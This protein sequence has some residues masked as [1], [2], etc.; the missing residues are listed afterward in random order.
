[1]NLI[2]LILALAVAC[3]SAAPPAR[4]FGGNLPLGKASGRA[5]NGREKRVNVDST[6]LDADAISLSLFNLGDVVAVKDR[7]KRNNKGKRPRIF[8]SSYL[9][10]IAWRCLPRAPPV[11]LARCPYVTGRVWGSTAPS[12]RSCPH[13]QED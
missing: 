4:L 11:H 3:A 9:D 12:P 7:V 8:P 1:M 10:S 13:C 5:K 2:A 6:A